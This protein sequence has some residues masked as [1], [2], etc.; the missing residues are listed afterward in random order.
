MF[1]AGVAVGWG[2]RSTLGPTREASVR[3]LVAWQNI[4]EAV[5]RIVTEQIERMEDLFA[6]GRAQY[7][8]VHVKP[9]LDEDA[10]PHIERASERAA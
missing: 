7:E 4:K 8:S 3:V 5:G 6:E 1:T 10:L 9:P 2:A